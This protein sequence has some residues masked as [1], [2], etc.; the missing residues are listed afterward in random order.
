MN[1]N[2]TGTV[3]R[4]GTSAEVARAAQ[5]GVTLGNPGARA[6]SARAAA[7]STDPVPRDAATLVSGHAAR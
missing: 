3:T 5:G 1:K 2:Q 4:G 7:G 6:A